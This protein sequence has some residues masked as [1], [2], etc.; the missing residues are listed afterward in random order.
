M[1]FIEAGEDL[2]EVVAAGDVGEAVAVEGVEVD[3]EAAEAGAIEIFGL[4]G[5]EDGVGAISSND[6]ISSRGMNFTPSSGMQ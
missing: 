5:E 2:G 3:V 6:R 1:R 4:V